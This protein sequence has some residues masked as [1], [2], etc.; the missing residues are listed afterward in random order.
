MRCAART[1]RTAPKR[2]G[3]LANVS[4]GWVALVATRAARAGLG[5]EHT[6]H[7]QSVVETVQRWPWPQKK[8]SPT[9]CKMP[10][11]AA[12]CDEPRRAVLTIAG[13]SAL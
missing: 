1:V 4:S 8:P 13:G 2:C 12:N 9:C 5:T 10:K 11:C 6:L 7:R 3:Q